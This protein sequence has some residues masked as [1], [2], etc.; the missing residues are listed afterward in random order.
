VVGIL[1]IVFF[2]IDF[3]I[4]PFFLH[5]YIERKENETHK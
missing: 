1:F 4:K 3:K 5:K 2:L